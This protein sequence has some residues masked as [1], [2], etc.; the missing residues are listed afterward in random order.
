MFKISTPLQLK[1]KNTC[2]TTLTLWFVTDQYSISTF[3]KEGRHCKN[4]TE[5]NI[6]HSEVKRHDLLLVLYLQ[7]V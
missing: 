1:N 3:G 2:I 5:L 4:K 7:D 6:E